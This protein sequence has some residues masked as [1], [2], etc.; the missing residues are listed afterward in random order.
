MSWPY[1]NKKNKIYKPWLCDVGIPFWLVSQTRRNAPSSH[2]QRRG[3][4]N[5]PQAPVPVSSSIS[6]DH[7]LVFPSSPTHSATAPRKL[8]TKILKNVSGSRIQLQL[9]SCSDI[10]WYS[11]LCKYQH[12]RKATIATT[13]LL[14]YVFNQ[15][16]STQALQVTAPRNITYATKISEN[17]AT[18]F[19]PWAR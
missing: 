11:M 2:L 3:R 12:C 14:L 17:C 18:V 7:Q 6:Q 9:C 10:R 4:C 5:P 15:P 13:Y 1:H 8:S 19:E 16:S